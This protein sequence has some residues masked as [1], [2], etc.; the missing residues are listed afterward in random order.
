MSS[1]SGNGSVVMPSPPAQMGEGEATG[2]RF[3]VMAASFSLR[4]L[5]R[6]MMVVEA[7]KSAS[8]NFVMVACC[9]V[10]SE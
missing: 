2:R 7:T 4:V 8:V 3:G 1:K 5:A 6:V 10:R 9:A